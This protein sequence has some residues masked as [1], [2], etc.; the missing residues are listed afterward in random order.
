MDDGFLIASIWATVSRVEY[1]ANEKKKTEENSLQLLKMIFFEGFSQ[2]SDLFQA[3]KT[4]RRYRKSFDLFSSFSLK[5]IQALKYLLAITRELI[6]REN[7]VNLC[8]D[9]SCI[10]NIIHSSLL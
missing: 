2:K 4:F 7:Y 5:Y 3:F 8:I 10:I 6:T 1:K 9:F